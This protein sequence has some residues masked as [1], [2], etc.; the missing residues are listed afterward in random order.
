MGDP[1][2]TQTQNV[3]ESRGTLQTPSETQAAPR[4]SRAWPE[5]GG[6][7]EKPPSQQDARH[8]EAAG[9]RPGA[10]RSGDGNL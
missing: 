7:G 6:G 4:R 3:K 8:Q 10:P 9:P 5:L 2:E 1:R